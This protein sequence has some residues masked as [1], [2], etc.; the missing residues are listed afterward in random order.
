[1]QA[2]DAAA[3]AV[4]KSH[5]HLL[6]KLP[7]WNAKVAVGTLKREV[8]RRLGTRYERPVW[9]TRSRPE[10]VRGCPHW[11]RT[12]AYI[13][14]HDRE[15]GA[16]WVWNGPRVAIPGRAIQTAPIRESRIAERIRT[17]GD[18]WRRLPP[19]GAGDE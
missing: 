18:D 10:T 7:R 17:E 1:M 9:A 19:L 15:G 16:V 5:C 14:R 6:A 3:I 4:T 11:T 13:L 8:T 2:L 12:L